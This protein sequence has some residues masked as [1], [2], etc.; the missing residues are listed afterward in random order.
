M[1]KIDNAQKEKD[2][3]TKDYLEETYNANLVER[4]L[5]EQN[6]NLKTEQ[7][8]LKKQLKLEI[9]NAEQEVQQTDKEG[10]KKINLVALMYRNKSIKQEETLEILKVL[11]RENNII[12]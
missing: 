9:V 7:D 3:V 1:H 12:F 10:E 5:N 8:L 6:D 11:L 4:K 2:T